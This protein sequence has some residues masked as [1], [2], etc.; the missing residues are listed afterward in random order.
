MTDFVDTEQMGYLLD[1]A[2]H[3]KD[4]VAAHVI[5]LAMGKPKA[6]S[7]IGTAYTGKREWQWCSRSGV[8]SESLPVMGHDERLI[9]FALLAK[10][11][12]PWWHIA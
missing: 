11:P 8:Y 4:P 3:R 7:D 5:A 10:P 6:K 1:E 12:K 9:Q 2:I